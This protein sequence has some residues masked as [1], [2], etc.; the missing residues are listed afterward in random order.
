VAASLAAHTRHTQGED[1]VS[2]Y[3]ANLGLECSVDALVVS[4]QMLRRSMEQALCAE[5][6]ECSV[7]AECFSDPLSFNILCMDVAPGNG[8]RAAFWLLVM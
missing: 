2:I 1:G 5:M 3:P 8:F 6:C 4:L 7:F